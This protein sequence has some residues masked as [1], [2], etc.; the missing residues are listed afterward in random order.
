L[1]DALGAANIAAMRG[2]A[3]SLIGGIW[4]RALDAV[5]PRRCLGCG[6]A[7][8][9]LCARCLATA[10]RATPRRCPTCWMPSDGPDT[11][12]WRCRERPPHFEAARCPFIFEGTARE[13]VNTL[14][15][16]GLSALA[17]GM[18]APMAE[19][20][21]QW[22]PSVKAI[23]PVPLVGRRRRLR[24]YN[25]SELLA[26]ELSRLTGLPLASRA[27]V[28]R[29]STTPQARS[30]DEA[31]RR[32]NVAEAFALGVEPVAGSLLL[33][34]DVLTSG[35]TLDAC[36]RVLRAG[37]PGPVFALTFARED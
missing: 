31:A 34:D 12:C 13:A 33:V 2:V 3:S 11:L 22:A 7:G 35:A 10:P 16:R 37:G 15:Y 8:A 27:L 23:V 24:G 21:R 28:R 5:F 14:K 25:Q 4:E 20:L 18:A 17:A 30:A 9:F 26:R 19:C 29:R 32:R 6:A 1:S 36:A